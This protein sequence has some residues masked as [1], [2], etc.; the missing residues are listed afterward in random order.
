MRPL[1][2]RRVRRAR[3]RHQRARWV[4]ERLVGY[5][6]GHVEN[7]G[8]RADTSPLFRVFHLLSSELFGGASSA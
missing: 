2:P 3:V 8:G 7:S 6:S 5:G 1:A 4:H